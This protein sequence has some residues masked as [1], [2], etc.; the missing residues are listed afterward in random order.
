MQL[1]LDFLFPR[2]RRSGTSCRK[3]YK[4]ESVDTSAPKTLKGLQEYAESNLETGD[5]LIMHCTHRFGKIAQLFTASVWDH[6]AMVVR[7]PTNDANAMRARMALIQKAPISI[8]KSMKWPTPGQEGPVEVFEAHGR[9]RRRIFL[10]LCRTS[11]LSRTIYQ[12][13]MCSKAERYQW[14]ARN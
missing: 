6:V 13:C 14:H 3:V 10:S 11:N 9:A 4:D 5:L 8:S 7:L 1:Q 12:I 2:R